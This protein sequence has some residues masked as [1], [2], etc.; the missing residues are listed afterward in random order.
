MTRIRPPNKIKIPLLLHQLMILSRIG[1]GSH[2]YLKAAPPPPAPLQA[3]KQHAIG[4]AVSTKAPTP[5]VIL[6]SS[7]F[8]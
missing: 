7:L 3:I 2:S 4:V 6:V 8:V 5:L 1:E